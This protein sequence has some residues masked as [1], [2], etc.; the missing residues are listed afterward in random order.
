MKTATAGIEASAPSTRDLFRIEAVPKRQTS[1]LPLMERE[2]DIQSRNATKA[3]RLGLR[4]GRYQ[5][6]R[7]RHEVCTYLNST[8]AGLIPLPRHRPG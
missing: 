3:Q 8:Y 5:R 4:L 6:A 1:K 2:R 7:K